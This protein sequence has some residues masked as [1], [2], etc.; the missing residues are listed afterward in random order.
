M[1]L[2]CAV[3]QGICMEHQYQSRLVGLAGERD[4]NSREDQYQVA[5]NT[6]PDNLS[7]A[8]LILLSLSS[9]PSWFALT[10]VPLLVIK[11]GQLTPLNG[12]LLLKMLLP[13]SLAYY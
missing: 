1:N 10:Q 12:S 4:K 9:I 2:Y 13:S 7:T 11:N 6:N 3:A 5:E 8:S